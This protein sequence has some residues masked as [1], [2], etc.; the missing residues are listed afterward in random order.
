MN[1]FKKT[2]EY[3]PIGLFKKASTGTINTLFSKNSTRDNDPLGAILSEHT[4]YKI[5]PELSDT[6]ISTFKNNDTGD[7]SIA[8]RGTCPTCNDKGADLLADGGLAVGFNTKMPTNRRDKT[9][10]IVRAIKTDNPD[11]NIKL[12][13]HS[14]GGHTSAF[15]LANSPY[16]QNEVDTL[17]TYNLGANPLFSALLPYDTDKETKKVLDD[18]T[19]HYRRSGDWVSAGMVANPVFGDVKTTKSN[20]IYNPLAEHN[21]K[22]FYKDTDFK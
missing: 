6:H 10:D 14:L 16:L 15:A 7:F 12:T 3:S 1:L 13:G 21:I 18:K 8:H 19:T 22:N 2:M 4:G 11:G 5:M 17:S 9:E 20:F